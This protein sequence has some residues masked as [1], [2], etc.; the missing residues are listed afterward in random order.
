MKN[1]R[2]VSLLLALLLVSALLLTGCAGKATLSDTI[3]AD[4]NAKEFTEAMGMDDLEAIGVESPKEVWIRFT[5]DGDMQF[6]ADGKPLQE[7]MAALLKEH[8]A[9]DDTINNLS[10]MIPAIKYKVEGDKVVV[11][12][13]GESQTM[14]VKLDGDKMTLS[15]DK[16]AMEFT[17]RK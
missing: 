10:G 15:D 17:K 3:V 1:R 7:Y 12:A 2:N 8:G 14:N 16:A 13:C 6:I 9:D 5:K 11:T 4:W